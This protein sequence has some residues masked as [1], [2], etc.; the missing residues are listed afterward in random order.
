MNG[1]SVSRPSSNTAAPGKSRSVTDFAG[2]RFLLRTLCIVSAVVA[3]SRMANAASPVHT[4]TV[5]MPGRLVDLI[6]PGPELEVIPIGRDAPVVVRI[7][8]TIGHG[9][10]QM[11]YEL[12]YYCLEPGKFDLTQ[13]LRRTDGSSTQ[14]LPPVAVHVQG[15]LGDGQVKP[16]PLESQPTPWIGGYKTWLM[17]GGVVWVIG[18]LGLLFVGRRKKIA[19]SQLQ[20]QPC[21]ADRLRPLVHQAMQGEL[22]Q[23]QRAQLERMLLTYW[24]DKLNLNETDASQA[25]VELR[26][27]ETAGE[28]LRQLESWLHMPADR[29]TIV[30]IAEVLKPYRDVVA[31][32]PT[33]SS[34]LRGAQ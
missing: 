17:L 6:L 3:V 34:E 7:L 31:P 30:D 32:P 18:L 25:I 11:R 19:K 2:R 24:R 4:T 13:Y 16:N 9:E 14:D 29:R 20:Q 1:R 8:Q 12:E 21:L 22:P 23:A 10:G 27:H 15:Q 26:S 33:L 5:G 28:L